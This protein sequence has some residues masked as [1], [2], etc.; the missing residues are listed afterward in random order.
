MHARNGRR[1]YVGN[2]DIG[3]QAPSSAG[4]VTN[5]AAVSSSND[6][7]AANNSATAVVP[8]AASTADVSLTKSANAATISPGGQ[9]S[10]TITAT[11]NGPATASAVTVSDTLPA[12]TTFV[13]AMPSQASCSGTATVVCSLGTLAS[14]GAATVAPVV[15]APSTADLP[16][17]ADASRS[18]DSLR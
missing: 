6:S 12:G 1:Q 17:I 11:N 7:N 9:I 2:R 3:R 18:M 8:V 5:T 4:A 10:Y 13:S 14:G 15:T 16:R